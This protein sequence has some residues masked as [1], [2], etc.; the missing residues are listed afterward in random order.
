MCLIVEEDESSITPLKRYRALPF[1]S[2]PTL[3]GRF[4]GVCFGTR[5]LL[6]GAA[7]SF[8]HSIGD[9]RHLQAFLHVNNSGNYSRILWCAIH[10][11]ARRL[12]RAQKFTARPVAV[13]TLSSMNIIKALSF[14]TASGNSIREHELA[15][16]SIFATLIG[17]WFAVRASY[18]RKGCSTSRSETRT[19]R[20]CTI[21]IAKCTCNG[22]LGCCVE[23]AP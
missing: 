17:L 9:R 8:L 13:S 22:A 4:G 12:A 6:R 3:F 2:Q 21:S 1:C 11:V 18:G 10:V 7:C 5:R 19:R 16:L 15:T 14:V 20:I 23:C